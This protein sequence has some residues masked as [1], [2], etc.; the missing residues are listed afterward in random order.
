L[1]RFIPPIFPIFTKR[2]KK[3][4][5]LFEAVIKS[6]S[7]TGQLIVQH[8]IEEKYSFGEIEWMITT[9]KQAK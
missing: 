8:A 1:K 7:P 6:V 3:D 4:N 2:I 5:R 9:D